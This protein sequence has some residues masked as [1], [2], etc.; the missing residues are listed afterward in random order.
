MNKISI[1]ILLYIVSVVYCKWVPPSDHCVHVLI[2]AAKNCDKKYKV[3]D[4]YCSAGYAALRKECHGNDSTLCGWK[5]SKFDKKCK[6][7]QDSFHNKCDKIYDDYIG[8]C[9]TEKEAQE[10]ANEVAEIASD[11]SFD[12]L[13]ND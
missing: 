12:I 13:L 5:Y 10:D 4:D 9:A 1:T 8:Q 11:V 3:T 7:K 6:A 2:P